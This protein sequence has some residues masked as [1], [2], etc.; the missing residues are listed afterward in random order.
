MSVADF[1][2][3]SLVVVMRSTNFVVIE[4]ALMELAPLLVAAPGFARGFGAW[5]YPAA[6]VTPVTLPSNCSERL[7]RPLRWAKRPPMEA[8]A[9]SRHVAAPL[10][11]T[12]GSLKSS[13]R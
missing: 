2:L 13:G 11:N 7:R 6:S 1:L 3:A 12:Y 9:G 5:S 10:V 8:T 4:H